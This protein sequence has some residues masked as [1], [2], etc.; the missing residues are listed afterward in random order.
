[1][2][3]SACNSGG[4]TA[5]LVWEII[6]H[7]MHALFLTTCIQRCA[8]SKSTTPWYFLSPPL[9]LSEREREREMGVLKMLVLQKR[10]PMGRGNPIGCGKRG[11]SLLAHVDLPSTHGVGH[12]KT[13][14]A[15]CF[16]VWLI[17][18]HEVSPCLHHHLVPPSITHGGRAVV[19]RTVIT[20]DSLIP[21][22]VLLP[23]FIDGLIPFIHPKKQTQ[24]DDDVSRLIN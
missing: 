24:R 19:L 2:C 6:L 21:S 17:T 1:M 9:V 13:L 16:P 23:P 18:H 22:L 11:L 14:E 3:I 8:S 4:N 20:K 15:M 5:C 12:H 10:V 7:V